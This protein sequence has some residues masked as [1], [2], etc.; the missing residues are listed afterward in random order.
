MA[1]KK[2]NQLFTLPKE[3]QDR[4]K[5]AAVDFEKA[6]KAIEVMKTLGMDVRELQDKLEWAKGVRETLLKEFT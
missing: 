6:Q 2:P 5:G 3:M 4:M 1:D